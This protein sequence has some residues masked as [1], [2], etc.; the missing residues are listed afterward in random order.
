MNATTKKTLITCLALMALAALCGPAAAQ[1]QASSDLL[2]PYFEVDAAN[3]GGLTTLF[4]VGNSTDHPVAVSATVYTNWGIPILEAPFTLQPREIRTV[5]LRD[6]FRQ[7]GD[8]NKALAALDIQHLAAAASGQPSPKDNLYYSSEVRPDLQ[9]G[10]VILRT[11]GN[12]PD[13]LWGDWFNVDV[14]G[15]LARGDVLVNIDRST[16]CPGLCKRHLLRYLS[17]GGFDGGTE[18]IIWR[19]NVGKPSANPEAGVKMQADATALNEKGQAIENRK[20]GLLPVEKVLVSEL[21]LQEAFGALDV[22]TEEETFFAVQHSADNR[23]S[24]G[25]TTYCLPIKPKP[26]PGIDI[27]KLTNGEDADAA[28]GPSIPVGATV[29]WEYV[30]TNTGNIELTDI[31]VEDDKEG[32]ISCPEDTLAPGESMTCTATGKAQACQ[33]TNTGTAS[34]LSSA[35]KVE[36]SDPS[37]YFGGGSDAEVSLASILVNGQ[38]AQTPK[39]PKFKVDDT[40]N[41][42]FKIT[43]TGKVRLT[44]IQLSGIA[45]ACPKSALDP[46]ESMDCTASGKAVNGEQSLPV[47]VTADAAC[48]EVAANG[49][50]YYEASPP[51]VETPEIE[52][53]KLTNGDDANLPPGPSIPV[54]STVN[55]TYKVTNK[56]KVALFDIDVTDNKGVA[57]SCPKT[58]LAVG[59]FMTC[60]GSGKAQACQYSNIG[61]AVAN[62]GIAEDTDPSHYLGLTYPAIKI[63]K[64][65]NGDDAD[66]APGP[67][68]QAG[69]TV[70]WTYVVTNTGD[71]DLINIA[72]AD[73]KGVAVTCPKNALAAGESMTCTG[74]GTAQIGQYK[75]VGA[76]TGQ[77]I[78][79][80][81]VTDDDPSHY[82]GV[83]TP[84][85]WIVKKTNGEDANTAP[86]PEIPVGSTVTWTYEV[87]N[88]GKITLTGVAV[89]DDKGV[90][91]TCPKT[92]LQ[93]GE[94]MTC[95]GKGTAQACQYQN[96]GTA[97]GTAYGGKKVSA[98]DPSHYFGKIYPAIKIKKSTN[99]HDA[100]TAPGP[101]IEIGAAVNWTYV[102]TNT[103]DAALTGV[104]VTDDKG[105][106]VS[107]PKTSLQ[108][109]ESMTCTGNGTAQAGQYKNVGAVT[110]QPSCGNPVSDDDPS[111]YYGKITEEPEL[112][113]VKLTNG[114]DANTAPGP[115]IPVGSTVTWSY[116][117]SNT[118]NVTVSN[119]KVTDDKGV[120]VTCPKTTLAG[121]ESMTCT[122]SG[123]A[124][125]C[126]YANLG[127][128]T[129]KTPGGQTLTDS[130]PSHYF[131]KT[132]PAIDVETK[133]NGD[134]ADSPKGPEVA[135]GSALSFTYIV[136]NTGDSTLTGI[137][138]TDSKGVAVSCP[139]TTLAAGE[140][141]TCTGNGTAQSGQYS[142]TGT[143]NGNGPC[144]QSVS[145][146]DPVHYYGKTTENPGIKIVKKTNGQD[147]NTAPGPEVS[148]GSTV[149]WTYI[150]TNIGDVALSNVKVTDDKGVAVSCPKTTL[151]VGESMTCTG[152]GKAQACQYA[153]LGTATGKSP[154]GQTVS[155]SDPSHYYG[156]T[157]PAIEV[158]A[159]INGDH[160]D[161]PKGPEFTAGSTVPFTYWVKNTGD[162]TLTGIVVTDSKGVAVTCPKSSLN[163][164]ESMFCSGS[165]I[166]QSGQ[167]SAIATATGNGACGQKVSDDDPVHYYG[168]TKIYD[169]GC[170]PGYWKNHTDSWPPTGYST[171]QKVQNVFSQAS[172]YPSLG[173]LTLLQALSFQ[174]GSDLTGA[175]GNL[176]RAATAAL[177]NS[178]HSGVDYPWVTGTVISSVNA[179]LA[180]KNRDTILALAADLDQDNN[181]GCPLN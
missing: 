104:K 2:L 152:S 110:G 80:T 93:P 108:P 67:Q 102:V 41:W 21:V 42:T 160:A 92:T 17:G 91:V 147:A 14:G 172:L 49:T 30:V 143:A 88:T 180:S 46:A 94:S 65:T 119:I 168:K 13:A 40:L 87:K 24:V 132:N 48:F 162:T 124:Q 113:I 90:A 98:S 165:G 18:V 173:P 150:V 79:G 27:I 3:P 179:A 171:G 118:G 37:H 25:L 177:L 115:E 64:A 151:A 167:Y 101:E 166:A 86:G 153:N 60:T 31:E 44:G 89:T 8:P 57:V 156:K 125:A 164:G 148:V 163:P 6:W 47:S 84:E 1:N 54:G 120:A 39:G 76:V 32:A 128:V 81:P 141:M 52:I 135:I 68:I 134:D 38:N 174:G 155:A 9:V 15:N 50:G 20:L 70:L 138:V 22:E 107:C 95:T 159:K 149:T 5:N 114:H 28:P 112:N 126:Q 121:G 19:A 170:T 82:Y 63:K 4:A 85:I 83:D 7:G 130:D 109:G 62:G 23:Y 53:V 100:D 11:Q 78:C 75:N 129:G 137:A 145:D 157:Y 103:G 73:D 55:W 178:A 43:N 117:V 175:A 33:Y 154:A 136:K 106:A 140:S 169:E 127:T 10:Y 58:T 61:K 71:V 16:G 176:L 161:T 35:G 12:R 72:V 144:G 158:E 146:S 36:D 34:A 69:S 99:G 77:S 123:K 51:E 105:V 139:K 122:G 45:A 26:G 29:T 97:T 116:Q 74:S 59:E 181:L 142:A 131:G 96:L 66:Q 56:G 133:V 111:H